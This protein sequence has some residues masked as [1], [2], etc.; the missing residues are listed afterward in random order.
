MKGCRNRCRKVIPEAGAFRT[1]DH[2]ETS[3]IERAR[4][5]DG[6]RSRI[7]PP[8]RHAPHNL[9]EHARHILF[10][11]SCQESIQGS[12]VG[13]GVQLERGP[14]LRM[15]AQPDLRLAEGPQSSYRIRQ[16]TASSCGCVNCRLLNLVRCGGNTDPPTSNA[17][18][19]NRTNPISAIVDCGAARA[20]SG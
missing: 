4:R 5:I 2:E 18:R 10:A 7:S 12:V 17:S 15:L 14:Q 3:H 16:S 19:S 11:Q 20:A 9:V 6:Y 8:P 13:D 1:R